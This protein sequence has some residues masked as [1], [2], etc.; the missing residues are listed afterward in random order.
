MWASAVR[1]P[2]RVKMSEHVLGRLVHG[3]P[4]CRDVLIS[5]AFPGQPLRGEEPCLIGRDGYIAPDSDRPVLLDGE[6]HLIA[7]PDVQC[8]PDLL[9]QGELRL[10]ADLDAGSQPG[11]RRSLGGGY[12]HELT[13]PDRFG[14]SYYPTLPWTCREQHDQASGLAARSKGGAAGTR[15][16]AAPAG[17]APSAPNGSGTRRPRSPPVAGKPQGRR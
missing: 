2:E 17:N 11:L 13:L 4:S 3:A 10:R 14:F 1:R 5:L 6:L 7:F 12:S 16:R 8:T 15:S 9:W